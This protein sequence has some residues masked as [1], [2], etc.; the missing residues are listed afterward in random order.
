MPRSLEER[1]DAP[2]APGWT[3]EPGDRI[4]GEVVEIS[5]RESDYGGWYS[6]VTVETADGDEIAIHCFHTVLANE[7]RAKAPRVGD[8]IG[9][10]YNGVREPKRGGAA[11]EHYAVAVERSTSLP[12]PTPSAAPRASETTPAPSSAPTSRDR[13]ALRPGEEPF[14][15]PTPEE[16]AARADAARESLG[17]STPAP[18]GSP[19]D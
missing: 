15:D 2:D 5:E 12:A 19:W 4:V 13:H 11:F 17:L 9:V 1:L 10:K 6:I 16:R 7:I 3:P 18:S 8:R 14:P